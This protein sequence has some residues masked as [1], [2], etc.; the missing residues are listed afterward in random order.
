MI[1]GRRYEY[2]Y[3]RKKGKRTREGCLWKT[4]PLL[5][6]RIGTSA[7]RA[8]INCNW[9]GRHSPIT[10]KLLVDHKNSKHPTLA[11]SS[12]WTIS[13]CLASNSMVGLSYIRYHLPLSLPTILVALCM[14]C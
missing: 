9:E 10:F 13:L 7:H 1:T 4:W 3:E 6:R 8:N 12:V 14:L 11:I 5:A 2:E